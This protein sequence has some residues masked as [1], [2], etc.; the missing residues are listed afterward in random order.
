MNNKNIKLPE[1]ITQAIEK[2]VT[3]SFPAPP[4]EIIYSIEL[5]TRVEGQLKYLS[6]CSEELSEIEKFRTPH[7]PEQVDAQALLDYLKQMSER[8]N[9][10]FEA[11]SQSVSTKMKS[12]EALG[13]VSKLMSEMNQ[14]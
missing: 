10:I 11:V 1:K 6:H 2:I 13:Q 8:E 5:S 7:L 12:D 9:L 3:E 4:F 14:S